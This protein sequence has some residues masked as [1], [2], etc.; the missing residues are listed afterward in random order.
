M[1]SFAFGGVIMSLLLYALGLFILYLVIQA[2]VR[3]GIDNSEVAKMMR[4]K[5]GIQ[6][7][8]EKFYPKDDLDKN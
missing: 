4:E 6:K 8:E 2:A 3:N 7:N 5:Y 1:S